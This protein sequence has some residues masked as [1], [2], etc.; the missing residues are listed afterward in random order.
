[1]LTTYTGPLSQF[2]AQRAMMDLELL[3]IGRGID[4]HTDVP[5]AEAVAV[6]SGTGDVMAVSDHLTLRQSDALASR[7]AMYQ[8]S[9]ARAEHLTHS[10]TE[11]VTLLEELAILM[12]AQRPE[13]DLDT[14]QQLTDQAY[15][16][17]AD[18]EPDLTAVAAMVAAQGR[19]AT[20]RIPEPIPQNPVLSANPA[21]GQGYL[22]TDPAADVSALFDP[23]TTT[24]PA[25]V[26]TLDAV[27]PRPPAAREMV[28][29]G[30]SLAASTS[31][32]P[33]G[34]A[35]A[36]LYPPLTADDFPPFTWPTA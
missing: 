28:P 13:I 10:P 16:Q 6:L 34:D 12:L 33:L 3:N 25:E 32:T 27:A 21:D 7:G 36:A 5:A 24:A 11:T 20:H 9:L 18:N 4:G 23:V 31:G 8:M 15:D 22:D 35:L 19:P 17:S 30:A 1:M 14:A 29:Y 26:S 2:T